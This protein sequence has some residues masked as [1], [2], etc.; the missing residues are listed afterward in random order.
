[1]TNDF[2]WFSKYPTGIPKSIGPMEY[3]SLIELFEVASKKFKDKVA[4]V[5][6]G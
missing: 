1:M 2:P 3:G 5:N 4:F 6:M